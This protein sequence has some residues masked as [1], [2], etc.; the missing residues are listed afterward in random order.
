MVLLGHQVAAEVA[1]G[2]PVAGV[3]EGDLA[4]KAVVAVGV[5]VGPERAASR[6]GQHRVDQ[7]AERPADR[8]ERRPPQRSRHDGQHQLVLHR[9][10]LGGEA[11]DRLRGNQADAVE[12]P[13]H[14]E[15]GVQPRQAA[16]RAGPAGRGHF[17]AEGGAIVEQVV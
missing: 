7:V 13:A 16:S 10:L 1:H 4:A 9:D 3:A 11:L 14:G 17:R 12:F 6:A 5:R 8:L 2:D 15:H